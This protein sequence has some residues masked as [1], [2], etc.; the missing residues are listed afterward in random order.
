M[1]G[2][3]KKSKTGTDGG[4]N[5]VA[6]NRRARFDYFIED[7][8]EAGLV[9]TGTEVK[10]LRE[11]KASINESYAGEKNGE[12]LLF[13]CT[14]PEYQAAGAHLQHQPRRPRKLLLHKR[15]IARLLGAITRKGVTLIPTKLYFNTR[16]RVKLEL[17]IATGKKQHDKRESTKERDWKRQKARIMSEKS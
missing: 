8:V 13:N 5:V 14:I 7:T 3:S 15:E 10:S 17:G 1:A 6:N 12:I 2:K 9:L 11:G 16:G 4:I